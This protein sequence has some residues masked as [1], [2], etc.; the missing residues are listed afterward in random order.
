MHFES[1][2]TV[3]SLLR[4]Q[5]SQTASGK[6]RTAAPSSSLL[7]QFSSSMQPSIADDKPNILADIKRDHA[8]FFSL[9]RQYKESNADEEKQT[10][11]WQVITSCEREQPAWNTAASVCMRPTIE[12]QEPMAMFT[13]WCCNWHS[14]PAWQAYT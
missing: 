8:Q 3:F 10:L 11:V 4:A 6:L 14:V 2:C 5:L 12:H 9:H 1:A 13:C 7:A